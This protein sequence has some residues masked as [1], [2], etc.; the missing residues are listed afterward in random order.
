[1]IHT[2]HVTVVHAAVVHTG[3]IAM[4]HT[5]MR[6]AHISHGQQGCRTQ[7]GNLTLHFLT[8]S[9]GATGK[10]RA[11]HGFGEQGVSLVFLRL[12]DHVIGF[13]NADAQLIDRN[14]LHVVA[15][16][17]HHGHFQTGQAHVEVGHGR[18]VDQPQ[19]HPLT[20]FE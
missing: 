4:I 14:R 9:Q 6:H 16:G 3:H 11:A 1:M 8:R 18:R 13:G 19:A 17:L 5:H 10:T 7:F 2:G 20:G 12:N 15:I